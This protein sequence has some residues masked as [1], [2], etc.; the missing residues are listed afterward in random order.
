VNFAGWAVFITRFNPDGIGTGWTLRVAA[1]PHP[2]LAAGLVI[3]FD[4]DFAGPQ[5]ADPLNTHGW[6]ITMNDHFLRGPLFHNH[7]S[8]TFPHEHGAVV[9]TYIR[10]SFLHHASAEKHPSQRHGGSKNR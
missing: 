2:F 10:R 7:G 3:T 5:D 6:G 8:G 1:D 9:A 4:P